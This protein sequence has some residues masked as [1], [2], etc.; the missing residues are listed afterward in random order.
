MTDA[1]PV[2]NKKLEASFASSQGPFLDSGSSEEP[3]QENGKGSPLPETPSQAELASHKGPEGACRQRSP[4]PPSHQKPPRNP[5][6][7]NGTW[8]SPELQANGTGTQGPEAPDTN[9][10][11]CPAGPRGQQARSL[12]RAD[13]KQAHI[14]RQLMTNFILGSFDDNS[15]DED[16]GAS[17]FRESSRKGSRA[18]LGTLSL[19]AAQTASDPET[20]VPTMR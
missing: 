4:L 17:S 2:T 9:G 8:P 6:S 10:L 3:L 11:S 20:Q 14:K 15:S 7:S 19:E 5:V 16:P 12:S 18:S 1:E 13:E